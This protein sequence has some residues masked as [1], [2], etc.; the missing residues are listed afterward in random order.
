M[1][2]NQEASPLATLCY[3]AGSTLDEVLALEEEE[4]VELSKEIVGNTV[5]EH[6]RVIKYVHVH[7][8][9]SNSNRT[10]ASFSLSLYRRQWRRCR[11]E[12]VLRK[13]V[14]YEMTV[15]ER[16]ETEQEDDVRVAVAEETR[17]RQLQDEEDARNQ[18][19]QYREEQEEAIGEDW[20]EYLR[21]QI[22][23][24]MQQEFL[25]SPRHSVPIVIAATSSCT[26]HH[27]EETSSEEETWYSKSEDGMNAALYG[28]QTMA[29]NLMGLLE[30]GLSDFL[31]GP[32]DEKQ[33]KR[34]KKSKTK[35][36]PNA[37]ERPRML[38]SSKFHC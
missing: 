23:Q 29:A 34:K 21:K 17:L 35:E 33:K 11:L 32:S 5:L 20:H 6:A 36:K 13:E 18:L 38:L 1:S 28:V 8:S 10:H 19:Q 14:E 7:V 27:S 30:E 12:E 24:E 15:E 37:E 3:K 31:L 2:S 9:F 26:S 16:D 22:R 25:P 4:L